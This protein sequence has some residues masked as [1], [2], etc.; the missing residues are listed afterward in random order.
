MQRLITRKSVVVVGCALLL[1]LAALSFFVPSER[2]WLLTS[3]S[4]CPVSVESTA[5]LGRNGAPLGPGLMSFGPDGVPTGDGHALF[6]IF[7][8]TPAGKAYELLR[9]PDSRVICRVRG[10]GDVFWIDKTHALAAQVGFSSWSRLRIPVRW[11]GSLAYIARYWSINWQDGGAEAVEADTLPAESRPAVSGSYPALTFYT[12]DVPEAATRDTRVLMWQQNPTTLTYSIVVRDKV[13]GHT[14]KICD[15]PA[16]QGPVAFC[17]TSDDKAII[18]IT[19]T[20]A[21]HETRAAVLTLS[22]GALEDI[23]LRPEA[24][25]TAR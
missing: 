22:T 18:G 3:P 16:G 1:A 10:A 23:S 6:W 20:I 9:L 11:L 2:T 7:H 21:P 13:T 12:P 15:L 14:A 17:W 24:G 8:Y 25:N 19:N 5:T 4:K